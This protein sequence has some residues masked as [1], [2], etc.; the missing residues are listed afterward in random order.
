[1]A[2]Q[3]LLWRGSAASLIRAKRGAYIFQNNVFR[4]FLPLSELP[5][6][7]TV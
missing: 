6:S 3:Y 1:M 2:A 7:Q 4:Y 5:G